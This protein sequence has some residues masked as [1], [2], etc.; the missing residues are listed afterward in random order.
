MVKIRIEYD[1]TEPWILGRWLS[2]VERESG[3]KDLSY[4]THQS[5]TEAAARRKIERSLRW[6]AL[7][8][9]RDAKRKQKSRVS[10]I[11]TWPKE[12]QS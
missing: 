4:K 1:P 8:S 12:S 10:Y 5:M 2:W 11:Y 9:S 3:W 6:A 7:V